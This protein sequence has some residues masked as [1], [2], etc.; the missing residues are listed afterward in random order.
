MFSLKKIK[1]K[2]K[3]LLAFK[4]KLEKIC[5]TEWTEN[6]FFQKINNVQKVKSIHLKKKQT[7]FKCGLNWEYIRIINSPFSPG[8]YEVGTIK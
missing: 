8:A 5:A 7:Y 3:S 4:I 6:F 1:L 2:I